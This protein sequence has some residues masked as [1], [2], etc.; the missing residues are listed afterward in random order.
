[1]DGTQ[2]LDRKANWENIYQTKAPD[3]VSW[4]QAKPALSLA[5]IARAISSRNAHLIDIGS[6]ASTLLDLLLEN[7]YQN[8]TAVDISAAALRV[9]QQQLGLRAAQVK[10]IEADVTQLRL[11][12]NSVDVWH[13]RAVYH[14]L[15]RT[16]D[17]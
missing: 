6:G 2:D 11:P 9:A 17:R 5:L 7:G 8:I 12:P 16:C 13:D 14:F 4:Y 3:T 15:T 1:M 10:W